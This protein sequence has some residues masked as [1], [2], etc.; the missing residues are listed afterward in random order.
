MDFIKQN[1]SYLIVFLIT[2]ILF[3][4]LFGLHII[5]PQSINWIM[6]ARHDW[7]QHYLGW[8]F[9]RNEPWAFPLGKIDA[10]CY[11]SGTNVGYMDSIP[12]LAVFFKI[13]SFALPDTFQYLGA[14]LLFCFLMTA[15]YTVKILKLYNVRTIYIVL[16][17]ILITYNPVLVYRTMHPAL[18][19]HWLILACLYLYL[20]PATLQNVFKINRELI[21][22]VVLSAVISPY[23]C[24]F[25]AGF[26]VIIPF[27]HYFYD[28]VLS[29]KKVFIYPIVCCLSILL[30]WFI[31]GMLSFNNSTDLEVQGG[32]GVLSMNL[33]S[34]YNAWG[35]SSFFPSFPRVTDHQYE[36]FLYLGVGIML[37]SIIG[38][39]CFFAF[40]KPKAF[41]KQHKSLLPLFVLGVFLTL[42][43]ITHKV[44]FNDKVLFELPYPKII[45]QL[46]NVFRASGRAAWVMFYVLLFFFTLTFLK[47]R[48]PQVIKI[49]FLVVILGLQA[50][51]LKILY[52][53]RDFPHGGYD[54]PLTEAAWDNLVAPFDRIITYPPYNNHLLNKMDYQDLCLIALKN[55]KA[56]SIGYTA[57]ENTTAYKIYTDSLTTN[58][59][60]GILNN[61]EIYVT[62]PEHLEIFNVVLHNKKAELNYLDGYYFIYSK[63]KKHSKLKSHDPAIIKRID[64]VNNIY[65]S[66]N[67]IRGIDKFVFTNSKIR[68]NVDNL[69]RHE[70]NIEISGWAFLQQNNSPQDSIFVT[71]SNDKEMHII[72]TKQNLREDVS[73]AYHNKNYV[74]TGFSASFF[75]ET[76][77]NSKDYTLGVAIKN[78]S[79]EWFHYSLGKLKDI[80]GEGEPKKLDA[81]PKTNDKEQI[82]WI[83]QAEIKRG[84]I[85]ISGWAAFKNAH[86][87]NVKIEVVFVGDKQ[88]YYVET[89]GVMRPDISQGLNSKYRHDNAGFSVI[90]KQKVFPVGEYTIGII[91]KDIVTGKEL[92]KQYDKKITVER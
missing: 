71:L 54:S 23:I 68:A 38:I 28:K 25:I 13:F 29:L 31:L 14:W 5:N 59:K 46:G 2:I 12:L 52:F 41:F 66:T 73:N 78:Q 85:I 63:D 57:R 44:S 4:L 8:E 21:I 70:N 40:Q 16:A 69:S 91:V 15:Y 82:G 80:D 19:A 77:Q 22:L 33:N 26:A 20:K 75:T 1:N 76:I 49:T 43:A 56:I 36:G 62:T 30:L 55:H 72:K 9:F 53:G 48:I 86:S 11:P 58:L 45:I 79:G 74:N 10:I 42:F 61:K 34:L 65:S 32:F 64:S 81:L 6:S 89:K 83:D 87:D 35:A 88:S 84:K 37:L 92:F 7:G 39:F 67:I 18:C 47:S 90:L 60:E 24:F 27:K 50:Y 51:D 17:A 3:H